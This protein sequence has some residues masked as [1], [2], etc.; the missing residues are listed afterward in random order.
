MEVNKYAGKPAEPWM[1][2]SIPKLIT[3]YY[4]E[5]PDVSIAAQKVAF[6][7]SG[8]RGSSFDVS[9]NEWHILATTK[10]ICAYRQQQKI[11][12]R[13][14]ICLLLTVNCSEEGFGQIIH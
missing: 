14:F 2:V 10:A 5:K 3:L 12:I 1:L 11:C 8:H 6:G 7:T 13:P 9:F 4:A